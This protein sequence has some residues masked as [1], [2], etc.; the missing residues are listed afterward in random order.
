MSE[1]QGSTGRFAEEATLDA[2]SLLSLSAEATGGSRPC[3]HLVEGTGSGLT[4]EVRDLLRVR[5]RAA[6]SLLFGGFAVFL[7]W[8]FIAYD[9]ADPAQ[10]LMFGTHVVVTA[11]MGLATW[12]LYYTCPV[13]PKYLRAKE[14]FIFGLP[15]IYFIFLDANELPRCAEEHEVMSRSLGPWLIL[16][17]TYALFIPNHWRRA[18]VVLGVLAA[19]PVLVVLALWMQNPYCEQFIE[20]HAMYLPHIVLTM[21][22]SAVCAVVGVHTIGTLRTEAFKAK[23][24]GQYTLKQP[25]GA[26]GMGEV[27]LAEHRL[28]KRP[29]AIKLIRPDKAGDPKTL[30]RFEREVKETAKLSHWNSIEIFDYGR[31]DDGTFYYVMEYLPGRN[32]QELVAQHGPLPPARVIHLL[33]QTCDALSEA[34]DMGLIHRDIKPANIFSSYRGG[35]YDVAKLLDFGLVK[36]IH[37][38]E[39]TQLT[40]EGSITGSPSYISPEQTIGDGRPDRRSDIYCLG[41]VA[42]YLLT[43]RPPFDYPQPIKVLI[44]HANETPAPPSDHVPELPEELDAIVLKCLEK[45][46]DDRFPNVLALRDALLQTDAAGQW[47]DRRAAAWWQSHS[48]SPQ[49][50]EPVEV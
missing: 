35:R 22:V 1:Q 42:Y 29:C 10:R 33:A 5:L 38:V 26:G 41:A 30:A 4:G 21:G 8:G 34:H 3:V 18:A 7:V 39:S 46:P 45:D 27:F 2:P 19:V 6:A 32:L 9:L 17:F 49:P 28:L 11:L 47:D 20:T 13:T 15:A 14:L 36:P 40:Q 16:I 12:T 48:A 50:A 25:L 23:Q 43:G 31:A 44:A 24:L 37:S